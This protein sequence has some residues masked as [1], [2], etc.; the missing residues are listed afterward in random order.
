M[1]LSVP[2]WSLCLREEPP[3]VQQANDALEEHDCSAGSICLGR[4]THQH[5]RLLLR[6]AIAN[7][8]DDFVWCDNPARSFTLSAMPPTPSRG[9][10]QWYCNSSMYSLG[11]TLF[12]SNLYIPLMKDMLAPDTQYHQG[13]R[14]ILSNSV[15]SNPILCHSKSLRGR[16][17][18]MI[19]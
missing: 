18:L 12:G 14:A 2:G 10:L 8:A 5:G 19:A 13:G 7:A 4:Y 3:L 11:P 15:M 16:L 6:D 1:S 17:W 9:I